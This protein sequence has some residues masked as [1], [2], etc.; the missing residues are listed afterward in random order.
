MSPRLNNKCK[1]KETHK[2]EEKAWGLKSKDGLDRQAIGMNEKCCKNS[3]RP[4]ETSQID[5][6]KGRDPKEGTHK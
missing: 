3:K 5:K 4:T 2:C 1:D 6:C